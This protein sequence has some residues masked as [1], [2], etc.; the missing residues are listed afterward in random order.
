MDARL[1]FKRFTD[2]LSKN[3]YRKKCLENYYDNKSFTKSIIN[4][5]DKALE[6]DGVRVSHE[7]L[8]ADVA[9][10][11]NRKS[12]IIDSAPKDFHPYLWD[13]EAVVE[14][15]N[16]SGYWMDEVI[17]LAHINCPL[18]VVISYVSVTENQNTYTNYVSEG[19][20]KLNCK[21]SLENEFLILLGN[22]KSKDEDH[23]LEYTPYLFDGELFQPM[24]E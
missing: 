10:W 16:Y 15:E 3:P 14:H 1:F 17:K 7:Y 13:L 2:F 20:R 24:K 4:V 5:I 12:E 8:R 11:R 22:L 18:R 23:F 19:I 21:Q 6:D 9:S